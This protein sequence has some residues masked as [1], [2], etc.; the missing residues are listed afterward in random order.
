MPLEIRKLY[1]NL[2]E[3]VSTTFLQM[4]LL[5]LLF[6]NYRA[7]IIE[8]LISYNFIINKILL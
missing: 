6:L 1:T 4:E 5:E 7:V 3:I 8:L 2:R